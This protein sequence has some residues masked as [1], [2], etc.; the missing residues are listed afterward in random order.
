MEDDYEASLGSSM[1]YSVMFCGLFPS[2]L[3]QQVVKR[4]Q[5]LTNYESVE[6]G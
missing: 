4:E 5:S 6:T 1:T 2:A 3:K